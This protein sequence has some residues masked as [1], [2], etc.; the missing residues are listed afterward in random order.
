MAT[1]PCKCL[2]EVSRAPPV[3]GGGVRPGAADALSFSAGPEP[4]APNVGIF[5]PPRDAFSG[6][7][8]RTSRLICQATDFRPKQISFSWFRDGK[9]VVSGISQGP[10]E[11]VKSSSVTFRTYS[12]LTITES[13]WLSQSVFTCEV[14]HKTGTFQKNVSS[15]CGTRECS[16]RAGWGPSHRPAYTAPDVPAAS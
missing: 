1:R 8:Q 13:Q 12:M 15:V 16:P 10:V 3:A 5:V 14:E 4:Q 7:P 9:R 11:T 6:N 2:S